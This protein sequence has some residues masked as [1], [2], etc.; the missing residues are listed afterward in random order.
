MPV[1]AAAAAAY[2]TIMNALPMAAPLVPVAVFAVVIAQQEPPQLDVVKL[3]AKPEAAAECMKRNVASLDRQLVADVQP[4]FGTE[5]MGVILKRGIV[6][7]SVMSIVV[8]D[9]PSGSQAEFRPLAPADRQPE[10]IAKIVAG[11]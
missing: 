1:P 3:T 9:T 7:A 8:Q 11:C 2:S 5:I 4:L 10:M 6:G